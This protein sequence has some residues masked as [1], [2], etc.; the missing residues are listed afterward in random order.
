MTH[1]HR[2][3][4]W[5]RCIYQGKAGEGKD[6]HIKTEDNVYALMKTKQGVVALL[7]SS[8][9]QWRHQFR[10]EITLQKGLIVLTGILSGSK[11]YGDEELIV[12]RKSDADLGII[13]EERTRFVDDT[14][15][16]EEV[17]EFATAIKED[18]LIVQGASI[19]ALKTMELVYR[20]YRADAH[21]AERYSL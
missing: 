13:S 4:G 9:T 17:Y 10:L 11:S 2:P 8:A 18:R 20:I 5:L 1:K 15:W 16:Q 12:V 21:W 7:H 6:G 3:A 14:S 19:E